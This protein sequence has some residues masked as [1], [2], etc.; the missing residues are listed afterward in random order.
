Q[1]PFAGRDPGHYLVLHLQAPVPALPDVP[2]DLETI[3]RK[4]LEK[5]PERHYADCQEL[6]D[7][8]GRWLRGEPT[9]ARP[10]GPVGRLWRW[11]KREPVTASVVGAVGLLLLIGTAVGWALVGWALGEKGRADGEAKTA[12]TAEK[13]ARD[14]ERLAIRNEQRA[15]DNEDLA[16]DQLR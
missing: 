12:R 13:V 5:E 16:R 9:K 4:C 11:A 8:L 7:D 1:T 6:A 3:V 10:L 15:K 14:N 2:R